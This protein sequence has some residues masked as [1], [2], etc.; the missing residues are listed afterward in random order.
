MDRKELKEYYDTHYKLPFASEN[1][2]AAVEKNR[3][4]IKEALTRLDKWFDDYFYHLFDTMTRQKNER[5]NDML[6]NSF[7]MA[8]KPKITR[9]TEEQACTIIVNSYFELLVNCQ[10]PEYPDGKTK[11]HIRRNIYNDFVKGRY[12]TNE[13]GNR[14]HEMI[15]KI[16]R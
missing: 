2:N 13:V 9:L 12:F 1:Y 5:Y 11:R 15:K 10:L 4:V 8:S 7:T 6:P 3:K 16:A 14:I